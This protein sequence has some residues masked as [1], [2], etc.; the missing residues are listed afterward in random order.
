MRYNILWID[1]EYKIQE[2]FISFAEQ[3]NIDITPFESHEEGMI[4]LDNKPDFYHAVI[5]DAK[6]KKGKV[7]TV[8][9]LEGLKASRDRLIEINKDTYLPYFIFTGQPDYTT[10]EMFS[11][12]YGKFY[13]KGE[14]NEQLMKDIIHACQNHP[15][16]QARKSYPEV[17]LPFDK[18]ILSDSSKKLLIDII[19]NFENKNFAKKNLTTQRDLLEAIFKCLNNP[20]PCIPNSFFNS[21]QNNKPNLAWC[22][23]FF[24]DRRE[25]RDANGQ[26][27]KLN[28]D[29]N[30]S[31]KAALKKVK[32]SASEFSHLK[33]EDIVKYPFISN[34]FLLFEILTWLPDFAETHYK[35]YI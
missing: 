24:E 4:S 14:D 9:N 6:V 2:D 35:N 28:K 5:L 30:E 10:N 31:I 1:D 15:E 19:Q 17:F 21:S 12:S 23:M 11:Q 8:T 3:S 13:N 22:V 18:N 29:V 33:E 7:A 34:S 25:V 27:H 20:I 26:L 16:I 32:E